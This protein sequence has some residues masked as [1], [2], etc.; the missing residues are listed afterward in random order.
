MYVTK[1]INDCPFWFWQS[2][3]PYA[4]SEIVY[5]LLLEV[6]HCI[7]KMD[8]SGLEVICTTNE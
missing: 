8:Y 3:S 5:N 2:A 6:R 1:G 4:N 7:V